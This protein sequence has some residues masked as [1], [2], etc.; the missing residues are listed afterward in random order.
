M[1]TH[2]H[3]L[4]ELRKIKVEPDEIY[5]LIGNIIIFWLTTPNLLPNK[6]QL[7]KRTEPFFHR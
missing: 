5:V 1:P 6:S 7:K 3:L 2:K 4:D